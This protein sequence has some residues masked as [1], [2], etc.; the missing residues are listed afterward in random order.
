MFES[1]LYVMCEGRLQL[2]F[3]FKNGMKCTDVFFFVVRLLT[4]LHNVVVMCMQHHWILA[5][6][7]TKLIIINFSIR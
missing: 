6:L 1:I 3:G 5:K 2:Q 7:S 4:T